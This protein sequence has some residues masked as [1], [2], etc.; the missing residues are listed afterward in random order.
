MAELPKR[1]KSFFIFLVTG[2]IIPV[3]S[4]LHPTW[5]ALDVAPQGG[6]ILN[7]STVAP[8]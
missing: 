4:I 7:T 3:K 6:T 8:R 5:E 1:P 2:W